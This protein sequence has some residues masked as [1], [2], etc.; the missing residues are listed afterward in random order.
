MVAAL[1]WGSTQQSADEAHGWGWGERSTA[2][3]TELRVPSAWS[4]APPA[5]LTLCFC[6]LPIGGGKLENK[7]CILIYFVFRSGTHQAVLFF[8]Y[9]VV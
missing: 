9:P 1:P 6:S 5:C 2:A 8:S 4:A 3:G 7:M